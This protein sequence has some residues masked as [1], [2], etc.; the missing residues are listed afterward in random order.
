MTTAASAQI[1]PAVAPEHPIAEL[2]EENLPGSA[3]AIAA[4]SRVSFAGRVLH[5]TMRLGGMPKRAT[6]AKSRNV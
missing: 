1:I 4:N 2:R 3:L 5:T 6:G